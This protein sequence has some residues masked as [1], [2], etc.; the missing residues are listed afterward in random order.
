MDDW[1]LALTTDPVE[2]DIAV[3]QQLVRQPA[4]RFFKGKSIRFL[5]A[6]TFPTLKTILNIWDFYVKLVVKTF[7]LLI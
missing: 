5:A 3:S 2:S 7:F 6:D 4:W 1:T